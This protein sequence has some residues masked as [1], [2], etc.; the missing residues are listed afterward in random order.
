MLHS[1][2]LDYYSFEEN[3]LLDRYGYF[4]NGGSHSWKRFIWFEVDKGQF[5]IQ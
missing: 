5:N 4:N 3:H 1:L 2:D